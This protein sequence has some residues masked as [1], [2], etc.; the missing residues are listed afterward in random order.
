MLGFCI[1]EREK[2]PYHYS[3]PLTLLLIQ[4]QLP[5]EL[6]RDNPEDVYNLL[7]AVLQMHEPVYTR[8]NVFPL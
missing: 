4:P 1:E 3:V 5:L 2:L 6:F 8:I 7:L